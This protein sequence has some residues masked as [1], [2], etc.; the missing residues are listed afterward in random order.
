MGGEGKHD[1]CDARAQDVGYA[2]L[3]GRESEDAVG[4]RDQPAREANALGFIAVEQGI[5][6]TSA[7]NGCEFP[8]QVDGI[9]NA[10]IHAL[11]AGRTVDMRGIADKERAALAEMLCDPVMDMV[12]REPVDPLDPYLQM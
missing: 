10:G 1:G 2:A 3:G 7:D 5:R 6:G 11:A 12:G 4:G 8:R 9:A